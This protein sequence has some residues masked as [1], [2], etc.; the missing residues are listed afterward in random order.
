VWR[1]IGIGNGGNFKRLKELI[2][3]A[4]IGTRNVL[5]Q[6]NST[7]VVKR[8]VLTSSYNVNYPWRADNSKSIR[9]LGMR[10]R[11]LDESMIDFFQQMVEVGIVTPSKK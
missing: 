10:Y 7:D 1:S 9:E 3:P 6:A 2:E 8:V 4:Q 11:S 5:E